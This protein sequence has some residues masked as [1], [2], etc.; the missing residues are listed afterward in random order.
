MKKYLAILFIICSFVTIDT[1][2]ADQEMRGVWVASVYN[3]DYP[4][5]PGLSAAELKSEALS[6]IETTKSAGLNTIFLQVRPCS[7]SLYPST[8][9]PWSAYLSTA[10]G[11]AP[12]GGFD[13][14]DFFV[15]ES[16]KH[17]IA[18]HAWLNPYR[19][20]K[21][22][23]ATRDEAL[24]SL[25]SWHPARHNESA[26]LFGVDGNLY[27][28]PAEPVTKQ[29]ILDGTMEI[30]KNYD[31]AGIHIDDYFYPSGKF[32]DSASWEKYGAGYDSI[33]DFR[34]AA[35]TDMVYSLYDNIKSYDKKLQFG[36]S[37][38]GVW[39]NKSSH[40]EG[41]DTKSS[42]SYYDHY[43]DTK[44]WVKDG[45]L[46]YIMPQLYW[47]MYSVEAS[48]EKLT[49]WWSDVVSGT[50][51]ALYTGLAT[52]R[53]A[54][55]PKED[56]WYGTDEIARQL[57]HNQS[58]PQSKGFCVFRLRSISENAQLLS[59]LK[60]AAAGEVQTPKQLVIT[61]P[62]PNIITS[63]NQ[64]YFCGKSASALSVNGISI[65]LSKSG[66][67]GVT[68][69]L[70]Y[71]ENVL[72]FKNETDTITHKVYRQ[73][74][75]ETDKSVHIQTAEI[76][77]AS[78][79]IPLYS[80]DK[81]GLLRVEFDYNKIGIDY[82]SSSPD[83]VINADYTNVYSTP[84]RG[85]GGVCYLNQGDILPVEKIENGF[86]LF[87]DLGYVELKNCSLR[88][89]K[90]NENIEIKELTHRSDEKNYYI[91]FTLNSDCPAYFLK[92]ENSYKIVFFGGI[93]GENIYADF[94]KNSKLIIEDDKLIYSFEPIDAHMF[95]GYSFKKSGK[96]ATLTLKKAPVI[97]DEKPL[98]GTVIVIDP[99]HGGEALG[100]LSCVDTFPEKNINLTYSLSLRDNLQE[101]GATVHLLREDDVDIS[102]SDRL[103]RSKAHNPDILISMHSN[104]TVA[105]LDMREFSGVQIFANSTTS[106]LLG[107][108][109]NTE[110][111]RANIKVVPTVPDSDLFMVKPYFSQSILIENG[112]LAN[113]DDLELL[114]SERYKKS[115]CDA[116]S[117][118]IINFLK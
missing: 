20:T 112:F 111:E 59:L 32:D 74:K 14:L 43:A 39:A 78:V 100:A 67:W 24:N 35:V 97:G 65:S 2:G 70:V 107:T 55:A 23:F 117:T 72:V 83:A 37:P 40:P 56:V 8:L 77:D 71:G 113:P 6:I 81:Y 99:G 42:Q 68:L 114:L 63:Y 17:G 57:A 98:S 103:N 53:I 33:E 1:Y 12:D 54:D 66:Y 5:K 93:T 25:A 94:I 110:L 108:S 95:S 76:D 34:R 45:K 10:Q 84:D 44:K 29:L 47:H 91:D 26:V 109:I 73:F 69:P 27:F 22:G 46:S 87:S 60:T 88:T 21:S 105:N 15:S 62:S 58:A 101:R 52:Y 7:D 116:I 38:F 85:K 49:A 19:I 104:S 16:K 41:S 64:F 89:G 36:V 51:V 92:N 115:F 82:T 18:V 11:T 79:S 61:K 96:T 28:N 102:L 30:V 3:L 106:T 80:S 86:A 31:V 50:D 13:P 90:K 4:S 9:F 75:Y 48:Y 118:G